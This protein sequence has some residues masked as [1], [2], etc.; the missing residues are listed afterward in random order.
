MTDIYLIFN[1]NLQCII[2]ATTEKEAKNYFA[3]YNK[4][5]IVHE[6]KDDIFISEKYFDDFEEVLYCAK[7]TTSSKI[8]YI[9]FTG[10]ISG[11]YS[12]QKQFN[13]YIAETHEKALKTAIDDFESV[14]EKEEDYH[15]DTDENDKRISTKKCFKNGILMLKKTNSLVGED[16]NNNNYCTRDGY[17]IHI[18]NLPITYSKKKEFNIT[19]EKISL[20]D[21]KLFYFLYDKKNFIYF[22]TDDKDL[23]EKYLD[24]NELKFEYEEIQNFNSFLQV[25]NN[26]LYIE[27]FSYNNEN[28]IIIIKEDDK[29]YIK[30]E[31]KHTISFL[32]RTFGFNNDE[33]TF[34]IENNKYKNIT[35]HELFLDEQLNIKNNS[36]T[37]FNFDDNIIVQYLEGD[38]LE[39][40]KKLSEEF[41][42]E[43]YGLQAKVENKIIIEPVHFLI[44][45]NN[46]FIDI[47]GIWEEQSLINYWTK[48][49]IEESSRN[50]DVEF[51]LIKINNTLISDEISNIENII[52]KI[53]NKIKEKDIFVIY[54]S[55]KDKI[56][57][58]ED[59]DNVY[60]YYKKHK[61]H[62]RYTN[63]Q[64]G[65]VFL[66]DVNVYHDKQ[67][68]YLTK[69]STCKKYLYVLKWKEDGGGGS[70]TNQ[71][72]LNLIE[73]KKEAISDTM[74]YFD[75]NH[76]HEDEDENESQCRERFKN[77][78]KKNN[79]AEMTDS[80]EDSCY[81]SLLKVSILGS[82]KFK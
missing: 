24:K 15:T 25:K 7:Y 72:Y 33:I 78:L 68:L 66:S 65:G 37:P 79:F 5:F 41:D 73:S 47:M 57:T 54:N 11:T 32:K 4:E 40:S 64:D 45:M 60:S 27:F 16:L 43:I 9:I 59:R 3:K 30:N 8:L 23:I 1:N 80:Y 26:I 13:L 36:F 49:S 77:E 53:K 81:A 14:H 67:M 56:I 44:K 20:E 29:I 35:F 2:S 82:G 6:I 39:L 31:I 22:F 18:L 38:C 76:N 74:N 21:K 17:F 61:Q 52:T 75:D 70:Y 51:K 12:P 69:F 48:K 34:L 63:L 19:M 71:L 50:K 28:S 55:D 42:S 46:Y 58:F 10:E 62:I